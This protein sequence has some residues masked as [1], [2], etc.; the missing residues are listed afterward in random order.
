MCAVS[1]KLSR[2][3]SLLLFLLLTS[4]LEFQYCEL[5]ALREDGSGNAAIRLVIPLN[6]EQKK[7]ISQFHSD[8]F[9]RLPGKSGISALSYNTGTTP[10]SAPN[11]PAIMEISFSFNSLDDLAYLE[12]QI[13]ATIQTYFPGVPKEALIETD[14]KLKSLSSIEITRKINLPASGHKWRA[15]YGDSSLT[16][17][18]ILPEAPEFSNAHFTSQ[19]GS[20]LNWV[21]KPSEIE[22]DTPASM[23][24]TINPWHIL[25]QNTITGILGIIFGAIFAFVFVKLRKKKLI[26]DK[27]VMPEKEK[28]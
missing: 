19:N 18:Y 13:D 7:T 17:S 15:L 16:F 21:F 2:L 14:W 11:Q 6:P 1:A 3:V 5:I 10:L 12:E 27:S 4:C 22:P 25:P 23:I 8:L 24:F 28:E 20:Q 9:S 26:K